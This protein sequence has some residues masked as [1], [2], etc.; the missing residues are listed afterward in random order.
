[1]NTSIIQITNN[2]S[3][4]IFKVK[5]SVHNFPMHIHRKICFGRIDSG[6]KI[7]LI[8]KIEIKLYKDDIFI[9]PANKPHSCHTENNGN[10]SYTVL[11]F[12]EIKQLINAMNDNKFKN[13]IRNENLER[14]I[15][16][17]IKGN[18]EKTSN[19]KSSISKIINYIDANY[20][21]PLPANSLSRI[22][23]INPYHLLHI[24]KEQIGLS[25]HQYI[26]QIR[27]KKAKEKAMNQR[28]LLDLGLSCGFYDQSH[29]I[30][31]F[32]KHV[33]VTPKLFID[34]L[35]LEKIKV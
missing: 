7:L 15:E 29:F 4:E 24:F 5:D 16:F 6:T 35:T 11:C 20:M 13:I 8:D 2:H 9:V 31:C 10:V 22:S 19:K 12:N 17:A 30:H 1:M 23:N 18:M 25:L 34:S 32:K 21:D 33:G 14:L 27:I 26:I 3:I 28:D